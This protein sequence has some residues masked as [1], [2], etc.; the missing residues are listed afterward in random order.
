MSGVF[1]LVS[2]FFLPAVSLG[3]FI[4]DLVLFLKCPKEDTKKRRKRGI[5]LILSA[6]VAFIFVGGVTM[7]LYMLYQTVAHM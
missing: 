7:L 5:L 3:W 1:A 6:I 4:V 2:L